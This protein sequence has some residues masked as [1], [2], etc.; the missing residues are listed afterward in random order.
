MAPA[1][2]DPGSLV[3]VVNRCA[4]STGIFSMAEKGRAGCVQEQGCLSYR[5][6]FITTN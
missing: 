1:P 4:T 3:I 6:Q 5:Y 2:K